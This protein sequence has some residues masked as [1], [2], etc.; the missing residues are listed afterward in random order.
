VKANDLTNWQDDPLKMARGIAD[1]VLGSRHEALIAVM[2]SVDRLDLN[3]QLHAFQLALWFMRQTNCFVILQMRDETY[4]RYKN[5]PPLDIFRTGITFHTSPPRFTDVVK[6]RLELSCE[7]L[8]A[9]AEMEKTQTYTIES[10]VRVSYP[11]SAREEFLREL[12]VELFD[13]KRNISRVLEALAGWDVRRALEMF[14]RIITSGHL[15]ET[16]ITSTVLG[17]RG[18]PITEQNILRTLMRTEYRFFSDHSGFISNIF[19]FDPDWQKP[20]NFLLIEALHY[21]ARNRK[22]RGQIGLEGY[23]TCRH[24]QMSC[25]GKDMSRRT[26]WQPLTLCSNT[27]LSLRIT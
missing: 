15:S 16:A 18:V 24:V 22:R 12:Y 7:Y 10:G 20:D 25:S 26:P 6:R 5:K 19:N 8:A 27:S 23:F 17:G 21:L 2:D 1:Y 9:H 4:E 11:K 3:N 13:R 14:V